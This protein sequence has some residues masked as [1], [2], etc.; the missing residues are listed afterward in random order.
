MQS[1]IA[2]AIKIIYSYSADYSIQTGI[3]IHE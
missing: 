3:V 1:I 2:S